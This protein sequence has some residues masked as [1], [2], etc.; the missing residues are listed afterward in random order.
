MSFSSPGRPQILLIMGPSA[1]GKSTLARQLAGLT[2]RPLLAKDALKERLCEQLGNGDVAWS[3][4]LGM[5]SFELLWLFAD[6]LAAAQV[7]FVMEYPCTDPRFLDEGLRRL[8]SQHEV[9]V[10]LLEMTA[11]ASVIVERVASRIKNG[12]RHP[13]HHDASIMGDLSRQVEPFGHLVAADRR[14]VLNTDT[15]ESVDINALV[16]WARHRVNPK[17]AVSADSD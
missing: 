8:K 14:I 5:A 16:R 6:E 4:K 10:S 3:Q 9:E 13:A 7:S 2:K 11:T 12:S 17:P 1:T 15:F